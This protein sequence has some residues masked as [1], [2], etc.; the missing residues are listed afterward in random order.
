M[1]KII[2]GLA[3]DYESK[4]AACIL[5]TG[6]ITITAAWTL[7][8]ILALLDINNDVHRFWLHTLIYVV[9]QGFC[10]VSLLFSI[11]SYNWQISFKMSSFHTADIFMA[12]VVSVVCYLFQFAASF[13]WV[14][15]YASSSFT[16]AVSID[17]ST[18]A[19]PAL[20]T[21]FNA[22]LIFILFGILSMVV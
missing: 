16:T 22:H 10:I 17:T 21:Y 7:W 4:N 2:H 5:Q 20:R 19:E 9:V 11:A 6:S 12:F 15:R 18:A 13:V 1:S 14:T 3:L 8:S